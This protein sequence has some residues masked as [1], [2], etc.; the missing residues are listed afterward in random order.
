MRLE[1]PDN[2]GKW[3]NKATPATSSFSME[4]RRILYEKH[5][6]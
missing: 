3:G 5:V 6:L 1:H 4:R 2:N